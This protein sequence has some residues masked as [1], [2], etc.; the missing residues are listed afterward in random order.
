[1]IQF[2]DG[3]LHTATKTFTSK[4]TSVLSHLQVTGWDINEKIGFRHKF[5]QKCF[6]VICKYHLKIQPTN[7]KAFIISDLL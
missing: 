1:M 6:S 2:L 4:C 3:R 7:L 5:G